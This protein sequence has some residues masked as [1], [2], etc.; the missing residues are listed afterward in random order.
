MF[1]PCSNSEPC[2]PKVEPVL[3]ILER[4]NEIKRAYLE[5]EMDQRH[6]VIEFYRIYSSHFLTALRLID[7]MNDEQIDKLYN[8]LG[9]QKVMGENN[10]KANKFSTQ[11]FTSIS[12]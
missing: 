3:T 7:Q 2:Q 4:Q 11:V 1:R 5:G 12:L 10:E 9:I 8:L 6:V